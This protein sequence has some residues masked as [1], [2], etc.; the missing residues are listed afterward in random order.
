MKKTLN[1]FALTLVMLALLDGIVALAL[2]EAEKRQK[3]GALV[4]YF[5]YGR[6]VPGK[7]AR[8]QANPEL[9]DNLFDVAWRDTLLAA[10][11]DGFQAE[12]PDTG[13]V[14]RSYGMSFTDN[15]LRAATEQDPGLVWDRLSGPGAPPNFTYSMIE[16]DAPNRRAGDVVVFGVLASSVPALA[17]FSNR[18]WA[19]EQPAPFTYPIYRPEGEG[20]AR[21]DPLI[22]SEA[23]ERA[24]AADPDAARAW[25]TQMAREDAFYGPQTF[26][27]T[28]LD[29]SPFMRLVR[30]SLAKG[31][32]S[33]VEAEILGGGDYPYDTVLTR[34][35][36]TFAETTRA[37]GQHPV[38]MLIQSR[39]GPD[40]LALTRPALDRAAIPYFAT[41]QHADPRDATVFLPDGH[42]RPEIDAAFGEA[43]RALLAGLE[44]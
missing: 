29:R 2:T 7:L 13:P 11:A 28:W 32:I 26:G 8:W 42:Y 18:S 36:E 20:L 38:V 10:S 3:L 40:L 44:T 35:I 19:F 39:G 21:I 31:H 15:I 33:R 43:F 17:A 16:D 24:L 4:R 23:A 5:E 1:V 9:R 6:S 34:M 14:I 12:A 25:A 27:L 30:R 41:A 22:G 37:Q